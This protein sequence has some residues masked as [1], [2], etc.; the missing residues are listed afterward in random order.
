MVRKRL[1]LRAQVLVVPFISQSL[2][3]ERME[4]GK[5]RKHRNIADLAE[6][7]WIVSVDRSIQ[8]QADHRDPAV[9]ESLKTEQGV[10]QCSQSAASHQNDRQHPSLQLINLLPGA[11][12]WN[13]QTAGGLHHQW[14]GSDGR[15]RQPIR[16][17]AGVFKLR[18]PMG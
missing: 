6:S 12:E 18:C 13:M 15:E 4:M 10:I 16:I 2:G 14:P 3:I 8:D 1:E 17:K 5:F 7:S 9:A 11:V